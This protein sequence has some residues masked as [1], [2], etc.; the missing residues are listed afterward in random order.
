MARLGRALLAVQLRS[1]G[2]TF[3]GGRLTGGTGEGTGDGTGEGTGELPSKYR[4]VVL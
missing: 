4:R 3:E 1:G 2:G